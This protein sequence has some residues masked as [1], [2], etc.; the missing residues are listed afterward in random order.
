MLIGDTVVT[1]LVDYFGHPNGCKLSY[2]ASSADSAV[3]VS[4][5]EIDLTAL[6]I[7]E[8]DSAPVRVM[9]SDTT[10]K[11]AI[12]VF[13]AWVEHPNRAPVVD[14]LA[15]DSIF[16]ADFSVSVGEGRFNDVGSI[17]AL[18]EDPDGDLL[19]YSGENH[20]T[21]IATGSVSQN[22][23]RFTVYGKRV[24]RTTI[25]ITVTDS[26]ARVERLDTVPLYASFDVGVIVTGSQ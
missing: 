18:F 2:T 3:A 15:A 25:T 23:N 17:T 6:A 16:G 13:Y 1:S 9:A 24:G 12:H 10:G 11:F 8:A 21:V 14:S 4:I 5:S 22:G 20:D 7:S 19:Q 26:A